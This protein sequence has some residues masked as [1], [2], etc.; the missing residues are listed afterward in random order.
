[1]KARKENMLQ[2]N[3]EINMELEQ[4]INIDMSIDKRLDRKNK[5]FHE[6][7]FKIFC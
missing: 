6:N 4:F 7:D 2:L 3:H 5:Q 1:L